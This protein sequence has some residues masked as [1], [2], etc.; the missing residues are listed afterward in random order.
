MATKDHVHVEHADITMATRSLRWR[1]IE[2][3]YLSDRVAME[4]GKQF[5]VYVV[6]RS[7]GY[8]CSR[9]ARSGV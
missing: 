7:H 4:I 6:F 8:G 2:D 5:H 3:P 9:R 1:Q